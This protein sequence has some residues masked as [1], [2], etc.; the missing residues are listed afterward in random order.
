MPE[1]KYTRHPARLIPTWRHLQSAADKQRVIA[2]EVTRRQVED[3]KEH[4]K[5]DR[6]CNKYF[7]VFS[8]LCHLRIVIL[9][10]IHLHL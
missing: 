3:A 8:P 5:V 6:V 1:T 9:S 10:A 2:P 4:F 7:L